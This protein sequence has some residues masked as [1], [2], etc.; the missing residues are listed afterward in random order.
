MVI[1]VLFKWFNGNFSKKT[2]LTH[3]I[4]F[5]V[6]NIPFYIGLVPDF[7]FDLSIY[8]NMALSK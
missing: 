2:F 4:I 1:S 8:V 7:I 3:V 5:F 6:V